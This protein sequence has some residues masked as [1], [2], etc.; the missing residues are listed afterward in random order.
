MKKVSLVIGG[1]KGIGLALVK[2]LVEDGN[3][4][5]VA[6]R[7]ADNLQNINIKKHIPFDVTADNPLDELDV[8][9]IDH[10]VYCPGTINLAPFR[11]I[12]PEVFAD[13]F[14]LNVVGAVKVIQQCLPMLKKSEQASIVLFSTVAVIQGMRF[15]TSVAASKG[16]IEGLAKSLAA[17]LAPTIRVNVIAPSITDTPLVSKLLSTPEKVETSANRHPLK[18]VGEA[19]DIA[20]AASFLLSDQSN[21]VTGQI[22]NVDGGLSTIQ[23]I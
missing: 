13:D 14:T 8:A 1:S 19:M 15:H 6:S 11:S 12:K 9:S 18:R 10:L 21:W 20:N 16:A 23:N 22:F 2:K 5:Y 4:V 3:D 7:T 17:E